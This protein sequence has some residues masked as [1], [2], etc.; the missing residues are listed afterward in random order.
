MKMKNLTFL[1]ARKSCM[2]PFLGSSIR[3]ATKGCLILVLAFAFISSG[4]IAFADTLQKSLEVTAGALANSIPTWL[5]GDGWTQEQEDQ[6]IE[7]ENNKESAEQVAIEL[8]SVGQTYMNG[9]SPVF[10]YGVGPETLSADLT[11]SWVDPSTGL[12]T[13]GPTVNAVQYYVWNGATVSLDLPSA[14]TLVGTSGNSASGYEV[15]YSFPYGENIF[16]SLPLNSSGQPIVID[17]VGGYNDAES[18]VADTVI[19]EP[20]TLCLL[21]LGGLAMLRRRR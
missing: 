13:T 6:T 4:R 16:L 18:I 1:A 12:P 20:A 11:F 3:R 21:G 5:G 8:P 14:W 7:S 2:S 15:S 17:G 19:P 9:S 10:D